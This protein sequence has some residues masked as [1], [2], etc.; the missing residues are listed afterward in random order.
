VVLGTSFVCF[1]IKYLG[2][3]VPSRWLAAERF[4]RI[5]GFVPVVLLAALVTAQTFTVKTHLVV[6]HRLAGLA[7]AIV[8]LRFRAPFPVV[9]ISAAVVSALVVR[10]H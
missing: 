9:V 3:V 2:H 1:A 5:N 7:A 10:L 6:D 4:Q 8:A